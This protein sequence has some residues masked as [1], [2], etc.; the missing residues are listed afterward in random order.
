MKEVQYV[1]AASSYE[2]KIQHLDRPVGMK[3]AQFSAT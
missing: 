3:P 2:N 1:A